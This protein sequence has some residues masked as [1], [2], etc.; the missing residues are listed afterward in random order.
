MPSRF[1]AWCETLCQ[2]HESKEIGEARAAPVGDLTGDILE[3]GA[4]GGANFGLYGEG[5]RVTATDYSPHM[6]ERARSVASDH[7]A[8]VAVEFAD[9]QDLPFLDDHFD[10]AVATLVFCSVSDPEKGLGEIRRVTKPGG[11]VR[12]LEH[13]RADG[14]NGR[15]VQNVLNPAWRRVFDGCNLNRETVAVVGMSG[16]VLEAVQG[17]A[18]MRSLMNVHVIRARVPGA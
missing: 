9:A 15:G 4:G 3:V 14:A 12:L 7:D 5:A 13:T 1:F 2:R 18:G 16:L 11:A 8:I 17:L 6:L 10:H